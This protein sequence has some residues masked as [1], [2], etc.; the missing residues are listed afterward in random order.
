MCRKVKKKASYWVA[1]TIQPSFKSRIENVHKYTCTYIQVRM[2]L[3]VCVCVCMYVCRYVHMYVRM[4]MCVCVCVH[5][6]YEYTPSSAQLELNVAIESSNSGGSRLKSQ[7]GDQTTEVLLYVPQ[8]FRQSS[9]NY[10]K[11]G[12]GQFVS[13]NYLLM[14]LI[15]SAV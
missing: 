11:L 12:H 1:T 4:W 6:Q 13:N 10:F 8:S 15:I 3:C 7:V 9:E 5:K 2:N 14:V